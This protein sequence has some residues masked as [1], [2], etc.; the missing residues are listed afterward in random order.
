[1]SVP[2]TN[3]KSL[4]FKAFSRFQYWIKK[5]SSPKMRNREFVFTSKIEYELVA[6]PFLRQDKLREANLSNLQFPTWCPGRESNS[7][8]LRQSIL[9]RSCMPFHHPGIVNILSSHEAMV[10]FA[11]TYSG[12]AD[13]R[14]S[15]FATWPLDVKLQN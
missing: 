14:V 12:F 4:S 3:R 6:E 1:M 13:R 7:H 5:F 9:S 2:K 10:G 11:P 15:F 8:A